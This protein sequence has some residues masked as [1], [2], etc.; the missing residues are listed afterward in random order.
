M[1]RK[2]IVPPQFSRFSKQ[3][4]FSF[5]PNFL[6]S[7]FCCSLFICHFQNSICSSQLLGYK[8][9]GKMPPKFSQDSQTWYLKGNSS[10]QEHRY[11]SALSY[12]E[13]AVFINPKHA[14]AH[15]KIALMYEKG[16]V[17]RNRGRKGTSLNSRL[18]SALSP[19][20]SRP[21]SSPRPKR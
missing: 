17:S 5:L 10:F 6:K 19:R 4:P 12:F 1:G 15:F 13:R 20:G 8:I 11:S 16:L 9:S 3:F 21:S 7:L 2:E 14:K 18:G